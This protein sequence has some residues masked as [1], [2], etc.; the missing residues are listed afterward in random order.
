MASVHEG[1]LAPS[2]I[3]KCMHLDA[4]LLTSPAAL[5]CEPDMSGGTLGDTSSAIC[6]AED[7]LV[8]PAPPVLLMHHR[9]APKVAHTHSHVA[10]E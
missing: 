9:H 8:R 10:Q 2:T 6:S 5:V 4:A 1:P 3:A 7:A